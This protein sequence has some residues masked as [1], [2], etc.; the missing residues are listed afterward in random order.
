MK[1][2]KEGT[3]G[4]LILYESLACLIGY[5]IL[6]LFSIHE[7]LGFPVGV[8]FF[9]AFL[10]YT[11]SSRESSLMDPAFFCLI[12][13]VCGGAAFEL[14]RT[15]EGWLLIVPVFLW[16]T[17]TLLIA[18]LV[19]SAQDCAKDLRISTAKVLDTLCLEALLVVPMA[20]YAF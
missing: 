2:P 1:F 19:I 15:A 7:L 8:A 11:D 12:A 18:T 5:I 9:I 10:I 3:I 20:V 17:S 16:L 14:T 13:V 4:R 6:F